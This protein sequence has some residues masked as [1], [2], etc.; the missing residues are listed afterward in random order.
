[1]TRADCQCSEQNLKGVHVNIIQFVR[2]KLYGGEVRIFASRRA[3]SDWTQKKSERVFPKE[4]AKTNPIMRWM[5]IH[6]SF[7]MA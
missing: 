3:L 7:P 4:T 2:A 5:L 6:L 1:M